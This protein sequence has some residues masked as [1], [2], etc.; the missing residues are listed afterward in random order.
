[1]PHLLPQ[2]QPNS[3]ASDVAAS[4]ILTRDDRVEIVTRQRTIDKLQKSGAVEVNLASHLSQK[5][6]THV[7]PAGTVAQ[8]GARGRRAAIEI[9][10]YEDDMTALLLDH[11]TFGLEARSNI[12]VF[13]RHRTIPGRPL[14]LS[15]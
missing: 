7:I 5:T 2:H 1:M 13:A 10:I 4:I 12:T 14:R 6:V 15:P 3:G 11:E 9:L 8:K